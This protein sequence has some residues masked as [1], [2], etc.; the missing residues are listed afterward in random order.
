MSNNRRENVPFDPYH[1]Q[2]L[3]GQGIAYS[4]KDTFQNIYR[5]NHWSG[6]DSIS[7]DGASTTQ[8]QQIQ[9]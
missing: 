3:L 8:T 7:G 9:T 1:F 2:K 4:I 5:T 6:Q